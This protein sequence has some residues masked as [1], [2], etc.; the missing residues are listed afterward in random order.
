MRLFIKVTQ[1]K[2]VLKTLFHCML[3]HILIK[4]VKYVSIDKV[5]LTQNS[6]LLPKRY[7]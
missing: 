4:I 3:I 5:Y 1:D 7:A 2:N 6:I